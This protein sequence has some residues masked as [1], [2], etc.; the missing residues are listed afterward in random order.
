MSFVP[1]PSAQAARD[2]VAARLR[3]LRLD[4]GMTGRQ[5]AAS[6]GWQ[7]SKVSRLENGRTPPADED[8]RVWCQACGAED[9][10]PDLIAA[11]RT[12]E[13][14]YVEWRRR[15]R[16]GL[17][18]LQQSR[19]PLYEQTQQFRIYCSSV[20]PGFLQTH[21]YATA[22]LGSVRR[23]DDT[24][25]DVADAVE[26]RISRNQIIRAPGR[27]FAFV[28]EEAVLH[29][30]MG[31]PDVMAGQLGYLLAVMA[32][33]AVSLGVVPARTTRSM[34]PQ[35]T[36][37]MFDD[38]QVGVELLTAALTI[39]APTE[40]SQYAKG[41]AELSRMAVYGPPARALITGA[42]DSLG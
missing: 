32:F 24:P 22:L 20:V 15:Q 5:V 37:T 35:E 25:D 30:V 11:S 7:P 36:F 2:A 17:R 8:I 1:S 4:A 29:H 38:R 16:S 18:Q 21:E 12:A 19:V 28:V 3:D 26:A 40:I 27:R 13:S 33:P 14:L 10:A 9:Q 6:T 34:W 23:F 41:F 31:G 42:I 39:T